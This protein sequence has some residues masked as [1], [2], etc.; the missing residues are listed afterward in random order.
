[1]LLSGLLLL[2]FCKNP[3]PAF[4]LETSDGKTYTELQ[5]TKMPSILLFLKDGCPHNEVVV[6]DFARLQKE[7]KGEIQVVAFMNSNAESVSK[8]GK[9][10]KAN[11]P[12]IADAKKVVI[13]GC[14]ATHSAD[15]TIVASKETPKFPKMWS[16]YSRKTVTEA[17][18]VIAKHGYKLKANKLTWMSESR[19][20]GCG[21]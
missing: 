15:F 7:F 11:F 13:K 9:K 3:V 14:G 5:L 4:K 2:G 21:L 10:L 20:S 8:W 17:V 1:M 18:E 12:I 19:V 6:Q 16:G